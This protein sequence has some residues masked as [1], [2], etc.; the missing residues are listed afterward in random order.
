M[1]IT[2][3]RREEN[4][5]HRLEQ[6][7]TYLDYD[8]GCHKLELES[9]RIDD[10]LEN[11]NCAR[12]CLDIFRSGIDNEMACLLSKRMFDEVDKDNSP[13]NFSEKLGCILSLDEEPFDQNVASVLTR[14]IARTFKH[15]NG[16]WL[17]DDEG[18]DTSYD[19]PMTQRD[20]ND[21]LSL[22]SYDGNFD[23][24]FRFL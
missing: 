12:K 15:Y 14:D 17:T 9:N 7:E 16:Y 2:T 10:E 4:V 23:F 22:F 21:Y 19:M 8:D 5:K 18:F 20:T 1:N 13:L 6:L 24:N 11:G 3:L